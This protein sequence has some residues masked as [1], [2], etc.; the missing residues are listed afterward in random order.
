MQS[1][2]STYTNPAIIR[3]QMLHQTQPFAVPSQPIPPPPSLGSVPP[4]PPPPPMPLELLNG[5][6]SPWSSLE[7]PNSTRKGRLRVNTDLCKFQK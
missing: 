4:P 5:P 2:N 7:I 1:N 3:D 6:I